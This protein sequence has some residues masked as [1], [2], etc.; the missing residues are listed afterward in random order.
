S[1]TTMQEPLYGGIHTFA[2]LE[3]VNCSVSDFRIGV[4]GA[5]FD[6]GVTY[7]PGARFGPGSIRTMSRRISPDSY[8]VLTPEPGDEKNPYEY[9]A[10]V[11]CGDA[12]MVPLDNRIALDELYK[13]AGSVIKPCGESETKPSRKSRRTVMLGGDHTVSLSALRAI[14]EAHGPVQVIHFDAHIDTWKPEVL[15]G[16][17][18]YASVN[19]GTFLHWA[20]KMGLLAKPS[21]HVGTRAPLFRKDDRD[22]DAEIGFE[23]LHADIIDDIGIRG[24]AQ[25]IKE[26]IGTKGGPVYISVDIDVLDP[27]SAPG[28]GTREPGGWTNRELLGVLKRLKGLNVVGADV[29]EVSP[30]FDSSDI[31]ALAGAYVADS[32]IALEVIAD[33]QF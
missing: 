3:H 22:H 17:S 27:A 5:P 31:S 12:P 10:I 28:T 32:L 14:Y 21:V 30:P 8:Y 13:F 20:H 16:Y 24:I 18:E 33:E 2:H 6:T 23:I 4:F 1:D 15:G 25:K 19:H 29:V 9:G 26:I 11:D 7:A